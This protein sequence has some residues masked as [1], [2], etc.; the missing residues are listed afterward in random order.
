MRSSTSRSRAN[1]PKRRARKHEFHDPGAAGRL[2]D[3]IG[4]LHQLEAAAPDATPTSRLSSAIR[5]LLGNPPPAQV[6][7]PV[8]EARATSVD[9]LAATKEESD[10]D[11]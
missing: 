10:A 7:Q 4:I 11:A 9:E 3:P 6:V 5:V 2:D 1:S 8:I